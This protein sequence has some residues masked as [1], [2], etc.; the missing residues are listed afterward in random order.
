[1]L[2]SNKHLYFIELKNQRDNWIPKGISQLEST[3]KLFDAAHPGKKKGYIHKK[4]YICN[5]KHSRFHVSNKEQNL[6]FFRI[7]QFRID[8][9]ARIVLIT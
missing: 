7:Y 2:T 3:I 4:A 6:R 1:M 9:Q 8:I 5:K